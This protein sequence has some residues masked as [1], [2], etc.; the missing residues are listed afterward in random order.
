M[1]HFNRST[2]AAVL[3]LGTLLPA[4][5][6]LG[7]LKPDA[8]VSQYAGSIGQG[9][10]GAGYTI[11][12]KKGNLDLV[13][14]YVPKAAGGVDHIATIKTAVRPWKIPVSPQVAVYPV[15][16]G[17]FATWHFGADY[18]LRFDEAQYPNNYYWWSPAL[19]LHLAVSS[20]LRIKLNKRESSDRA[21]ALYSEFNTNDLYAVSWW[22]NRET[23]SFFDI[24]R[25]GVGLRIYF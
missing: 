10:I 13:Y 12:N 24:V 15:N 22:Q 20:E 21:I 4:R 25:A 9:S 18:D 8:L 3:L 5:A 7:F 23:V 17:L 14:G 6:Q 11:F 19:R 1:W 2:I 16:P